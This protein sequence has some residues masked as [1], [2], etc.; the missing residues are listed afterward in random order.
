MR[1]VSA[2]PLH[3]LCGW[4]KVWPLRGH[5]FIL[6]FYGQPNSIWAMP[7]LEGARVA[8]RGKPVCVNPRPRLHWAPSAECV[9]GL[10]LALHG[11]RSSRGLMGKAANHKGCPLALRLSPDDNHSDPWAEKASHG[12]MCKPA[13]STPPIGGTSPMA[14]G[15]QREAE[16]MAH[17]ERRLSS[18]P[19]E[20]GPRYPMTR[21][22]SPHHTAALGQWSRPPGRG[23]SYVGPRKLGC[24][25]DS[26]DEKGKMDGLH[27]AEQ[28]CL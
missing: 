9:A 2:L 13:K 16:E 18:P 26:G 7:G 17:G 6:L 25:W 4:V 15:I 10:W 19:S 1:L 3:A 24:V 12:P 8:G 11:N 27:E 14:G 5:N 23:R 21:A 22:A 28:D 20:Q